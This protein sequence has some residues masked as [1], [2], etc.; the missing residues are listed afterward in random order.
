[1]N[2]LF[3]RLGDDNFH[4]V[5]VL[6]LKH[7]IAEHLVNQIQA[8]GLDAEAM[9]PEGVERINALVEPR[10]NEMAVNWYGGF[11]QRFRRDNPGPAMDWLVEAIG[12]EAEASARQ[13]AM[14]LLP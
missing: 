5:V 2:V 11:K 6:L 9:A 10:G 4:E 1:M 8:I 14:D 12:A 3:L 13:I 7:L